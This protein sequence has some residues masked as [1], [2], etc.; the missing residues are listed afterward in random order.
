MIGRCRPICNESELLARCSIKGCHRT[1]DVGRRSGRGHVECVDLSRNV[2]RRRRSPHSVRYCVTRRR[3][4]SIVTGLHRPNTRSPQREQIAVHGAWNARDGR[5]VDQRGRR[6]AE[7]HRITLR[8]SDCRTDCHC[9]RQKTLHHALPRDSKE[10]NSVQ[11]R[12]SRRRH[13]V[14]MYTNDIPLHQLTHPLHR[15]RK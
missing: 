7:I 5:L 2:R 13:D 9:R 15:G 4:L 12:G 3:T 14:C 1:Y 10:S 6:C 8:R 11:S